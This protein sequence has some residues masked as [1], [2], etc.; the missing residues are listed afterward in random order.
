MK[1][2]LTKKPV[3][4]RCFSITGMTGITGLI[5]SIRERF[6]RSWVNNLMVF[7]KVVLVLKN[8]FWSCNLVVLLQH[9]FG[10]TTLCLRF[11]SLRRLTRF[12]SN[13]R[14]LQ[15]KI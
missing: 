2:N 1:Q 4:S 8:W 9:R 6:L 11:P 10:I 3:I 15:Q 14:F 7:K 5:F 12:C 13:Q